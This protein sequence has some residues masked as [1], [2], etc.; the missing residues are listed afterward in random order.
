MPLPRPPMSSDEDNKEMNNEKHAL[1]SFP[2]SP[3]QKGFSQ[4]VI[5]EAVTNEETD[6]LSE[7]P[8]ES[9]KMYHAVELNEEPEEIKTPALPKPLKN[10]D[11]YVKIDKFSSA[12]KA[13]EAAQLKIDE[14]QEL[15]KVIRETKMREEQELEY[16]EKETATAKAHIQQVTENIFS[17]TE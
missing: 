7:A 12:K 17:K 8:K 14:M 2:D 13:L 10:K 11:V 5:K 3:A 6:E 16:W 1:P 4:S 15:L 9:G